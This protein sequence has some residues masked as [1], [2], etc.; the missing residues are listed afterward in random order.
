MNQGHEHVSV[1][2][3]GLD[4]WIASGGPLTTATPPA[5]TGDFPTR[6]W[7]DTVDRIAVR[8]REDTTILIDA[9]TA[10]R[11]R[12]EVEPVDLK[13]GHIP[14]A[15][16]APLTDNLDDDMTFMSPSEL[17][18]RFAA[19]GIGDETDVISHCGSGVTACHNILAM[20]VAGIPMAD[21]YVGSW[22][23]WSA[24]GMSVATGDSSS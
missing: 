17:K 15:L 21:L 9:R 18:T 2:D 11:Y 10:E 20:T 1:L 6:P 22:S 3:G 4:A 13:A 19:L 24:S 16:S 12:G 7:R 5:L 8:D 23:D 14:G